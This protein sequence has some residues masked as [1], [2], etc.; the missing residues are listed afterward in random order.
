MSQSQVATPSSSL[1]VRSS[2]PLFSGMD[3]VAGIVA[4]I[5]ILGPLCGA[6]FFVG[7]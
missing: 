1:Y 3:V 5:M 4:V 6:A 2:G 7:H